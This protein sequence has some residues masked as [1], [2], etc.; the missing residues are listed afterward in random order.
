[1]RVKA[2][3]GASAYSRRD[4]SAADITNIFNSSLAA[5]SRGLLADDAHSPICLSHAAKKD[6]RRLLG[7][8]PDTLGLLGI[9]TSQE[10]RGRIGRFSWRFVVV[11]LTARKRGC[12]LGLTRQGEA[13]FSV[14]EG[15]IPN[16]E[17]LADPGNTLIEIGGEKSLNL[18]FSL[19]CPLYRYSIFHSTALHM[20]PSLKLK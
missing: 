9:L 13:P 3:G 4:I 11:C 2:G 12:R 6:L 20:A 8:P 15:A 1:M 10:N 5:S 19:R 17:C 16:R 18:N 14:S 7:D